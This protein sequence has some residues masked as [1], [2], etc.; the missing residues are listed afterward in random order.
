MG[1]KKNKNMLIELFN[2]QNYKV[3]NKYIATCFVL[4]FTV[5]FNVAANLKNIPLQQ[6]VV[7]GKVT[8]QDGIG[9][10]GVTVQV[11]GTTNRRTTNE[12]GNYSISIPKSGST[13]VYTYIG[14]KTES[15]LITD[16]K[17]VNVKLVSE[18]TTLDDVVVI[19]YGS[20]KKSDL[21]G[22]VGQVDMKDMMEA[23][24]GSFEEALAGR[25][26]G[27]Q[28]SSADGQPGSSMEIVIRG[29]NSLTQ[30]NSPLY[31]IDGFPMENPDNA[32]INPEDIESIN[33]L[34]DASATAIYGA[35]GANGVIIIETKK[36]K[37]GKP[38]IS[39][40]VSLGFQQVQ[41]KMEMMTP[42]DFV[43][44][45]NEIS[46]SRTREIYTRGALDPSN[47]LYD[48][49]GRKSLEDYRNMKGIDWQD[50][51]FRNA[52]MQNHNVSIRGGNSKTKY[53][54]S[55]SL[56]DQQGIIYNSGSKRAQGRI[57]IDQT[58]SKK[59]RGGITANYSENIRYGQ[60]VNAGAGG[61]FTSYLL[62]Q[63]WAYRPV[64][65]TIGL[66]L[67]EV[68]DDAAE[69]VN[70]SDLRFSPKVTAENDYTRVNS[71]NFSSNAYLEYDILKNLKLKVTGSI[72][73]TLSESKRFYNSK[74]PQGSPRN[75]G[76]ARQVNGSYM[77]TE[78]TLWSNENYLTYNVTFKKHHKFNIVAGLSYQENLN[79]NYG[80]SSERIT[81]EYLGMY[82]LETGRLYG[83]SAG[84]SDFGLT[85]VYGRMEY[86]YKSKYLITG[87]FR[88]DGSSKFIGGNKWSRFPSGAVAWNM[89]KESFLS[90]TDWL[91]ESKLRIGYGVTGNNRIGSYDFYPQMSYGVG[92]TY[93]FENNGTP[94]GGI[95]PSKVGNPDLRWE[96]TEQMN[97]GYD[98]GLFKNRMS[99]TVDYYRKKTND[100]LL[101][102]ELP[103]A[104]GF[105]REFKNIGSIGN[106]GLEFTLN[107]TNIQ[108]KSFTWRSS[109]NIAF[110]ENKILGLTR[111]QESL[112]SLMSVGQNSANLY[113]SR[114][115]YPAGMFYG[116]IFDGIYQVEDFDQ[117]S[118]GKYTL[119][120]QLPT[121]GSSREDIQPGHIKYKDL[122]EDGVVDTRDMSIIG[123]GQPI[124]T[125]G[126]S[127]NFSYKGFYLNI[128]LQWS[129]GNDVFNANRMM[130]DGNYINLYNVNQ[131]ASGN[132]RW[133]PENKSNT[134]FKVG[135]Q[136]PAGNFS[137]RVIEDGSYL[138]L[139]TVSLAYTIPSSF[140][141][142]LK[143]NKISF[144]VAAQNLLTFTKYTGMD[145]EV[146]V[147]HSV[148]TPGLDYSPY[149]QARTITFG[150]N[151]TP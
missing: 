35:R 132:D 129:Y 87:T 74:T 137:D 60:P 28:V 102:A 26:A 144:R 1:F 54:L 29:A 19:G 61:N 10:P 112:F 83:K 30:S 98:L 125:G 51:I 47:P 8:D 121:N 65:G 130:F 100:L 6:I 99:L 86:N 136:G 131:Y 96:S 12:V 146:S 41:K 117:N 7:T 78:P 138:R 79:E 25:V 106:N 44:L 31:V 145:P 111:N 49:N 66:D 62:Y 14:F 101:N 18:S 109:F 114:I 36:G 149:P 143:V 135:G 124:H 22:A 92:T 52:M 71:T 82:G 76:L 57:T 90:G 105:L 113:V 133:T 15:R 23:P 39:F 2:I 33:I 89:K 17:V 45:Q 40:N 34:K 94:P 95:V 150:L 110:N 46:S 69:F 142:R 67:Q 107:T 20:V 119:K 128:F 104:T 141:K 27:V 85:S 91:S 151:V 32:A 127:N 58:I 24:V 93:P 72:S 80:F 140:T 68:E 97:I 55:G 118:S 120:S 123:R 63:A 43:N 48:P 64:T 16:Q 88:F 53:S 75:N 50:I 4:V 108:S 103:S 9:I 122:N 116:F 73:N 11:K 81:Q 3:L 147:R 115:G 70:A 21:T 148:L 134:L 37:I 59:L 38:V 56:F 139:K 84:A 77:Y 42:W 126:F 13:L 5:S